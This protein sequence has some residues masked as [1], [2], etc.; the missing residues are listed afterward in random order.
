MSHSLEN[1][2]QDRNFIA[3]GVT[4]VPLFTMAGR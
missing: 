2:H 4:C 1:I 3:F